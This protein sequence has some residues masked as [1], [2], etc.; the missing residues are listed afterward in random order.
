MI[1]ETKFQEAALRLNC[2]IAVIKAVAKTESNGSGF[3]K[4]GQVV[5]LFEPHIFWKQLQINGID[6]NTVLAKTPSYND[7]LYPKWGTYSYGKNS[8]QHNRL[9]RAVS[10]NRNAAL[11]SA[12]WGLFQVLGK[13]WKSLG[14]NSIQEFINEVSKDEDGQMEVFIRY[15]IV[16]NLAN[17]LHNLQFDLFTS[18][19]NGKGQ[20]VKYSKILRDNYNYFKNK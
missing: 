16:N 4:D 10:I 8:E 9:E 15:V 12:S 3:L 7:I 5:I 19:Y 14:Y 6:P 13:W 17:Y 18:G 11:E 1:T 2:S 20:V